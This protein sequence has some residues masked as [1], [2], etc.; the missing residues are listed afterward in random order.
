MISTL[1]YRYISAPLMKDKG[2]NLS[3]YWIINN[4]NIFKLCKTILILALDFAHKLKLT[5]RESFQIYTIILCI[6]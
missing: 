1:L 2:L 5:L 3:I 6:K 4:T